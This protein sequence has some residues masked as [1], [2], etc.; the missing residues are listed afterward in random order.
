M[1]IKIRILLI[2]ATVVCFL[3]LKHGVKKGKLRSDYMM[4]WIIGSICLIIISIF[5]QIIYALSDIIGVISPANAVFLIV[6][7]FLIILVFI[8]FN[9]VAALEEKQ[10][11]IIQE[12]SMERAKREESDYGNRNNKD[13]E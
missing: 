6:I 3:F 5:P 4:G 1:D 9:K 13:D 2:V 12:I 11:D 10:K 8:L 7:F